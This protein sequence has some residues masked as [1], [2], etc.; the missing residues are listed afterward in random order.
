MNTLGT[1]VLYERKEPGRTEEALQAWDAIASLNNDVITDDISKGLEQLREKIVAA[2]E[3]YDKL[4]AYGFTDGYEANMEY[5][6]TL[7]Q[8]LIAFKKLAEL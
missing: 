6:T 3:C 5:L 7:R 1:D 2:E 4:K 8:S